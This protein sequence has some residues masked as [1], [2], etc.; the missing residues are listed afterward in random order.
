MHKKIWISTITLLLTGF[1]ASAL[2]FIVPTHAEEINQAGQDALRFLDQTANKAGL[3]DRDPSGEARGD[4]PVLNVI[5]T[6]IN[7]ILGF[8]GIIFFIQLFW[9]GFRWMTSGGNEEVVNEAKKTIKSAVIGIV[10]I[11]SA[12]VITNFLL[13]K[14]AQLQSITPI[15][16]TPPST[17]TMK[18]CILKMTELESNCLGE[19]LQFSFGSTRN[20]CSSYFNENELQDEGLILCS[21]TWDGQSL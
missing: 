4:T 18:L 6:I 12:F 10:I 5:G 16:S 13:N 1:T 14:L 7:V 15:S 21:I 11:F 20:E 19:M 8:V 3:T 17:E 9:A 2:I